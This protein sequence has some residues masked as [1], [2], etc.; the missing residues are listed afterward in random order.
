MDSMDSKNLA[1]KLSAY[2]SDALRAEQTGSGLSLP[3]MQAKIADFH[4]K[5]SDFNC[6]DDISVITKLEI[7]S[8]LERLEHTY[9]RLDK[10][11]SDFDE[12]RAR[13]CDVEKKVLNRNKF[14]RGDK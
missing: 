9:Q 14:K 12:L 11:N 6:R 2:L 1:D 7:K 8:I 13:A 4:T 3:E 5:I 10:I